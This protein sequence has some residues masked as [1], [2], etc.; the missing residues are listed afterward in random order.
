MQKY[1]PKNEPN[2]Y[3]LSGYLAGDALRRGRQARGPEPHARRGSSPR[4]RRIKGLDT[5]IVPPITIGPDHETQKQGFWVKVEKGRF[6]Q[7][8]DWLKSE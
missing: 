3:S 5:G 6:Q 4:S 1:F 7:L 2:R 8:T